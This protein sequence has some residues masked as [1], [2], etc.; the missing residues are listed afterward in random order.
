[1]VLFNYYNK[2][3]L[4]WFYY[5]LICYHCKYFLQFVSIENVICNSWQE[6]QDNI[7][8]FTSISFQY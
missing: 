4:E 5:N 3:C 2:N 6:A 7:D 1:M 8:L